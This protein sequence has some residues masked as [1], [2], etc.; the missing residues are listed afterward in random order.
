MPYYPRA[1]APHLRA[2]LQ[3]FP[4]VAIT[5]P[6][7]AG[8]STLLMQELGNTYTY[9]TFDDQ[10]II[11]EFYDDPKRFM[12]RYNHRVIFDEVQK[13]PEIFDAI[14]L[15]VDK[16]RSEYGQFILTG[17]SQFTMLK[18]IT[19]SLAGRIGLLTLLPLQCFEI[20]TELRL[21]SQYK[22]GYPELI[23]RNFQYADDWYKAYLTTYLERD[24]RQLLN[25][26]DM[27]AF[28]QLLKLLASQ[29]S[30]PLQISNLATNI[31][32]SVMTIKRWISVLE[33]SYIIF[34]LPPFYN[35]YGKRLIKRSKVY[36]YDPGLVAYLTRITTEDLFENGPLTGELFENYIVSEVKKK[37]CHS[38]VHA[39]LYYLKTEHGVEVDLI[40]DYTTHKQFVEI[41]HSSTFKPD[42][43]KA[44]LKFIQSKDRGVLVYNGTTRPYEPNLEIQYYQDFLSR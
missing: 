43:V 36:F 34:L 4:V 14:K 38:N 24:V 29:V 3:A 28:H 18:S 26:G 9:V 32:V 6:R 31:G 15:I 5:G 17:S 12:N 41:K 27:N 20:P 19:E 13:V 22:G 39:D 21:Q 33:A 40:V 42:M 30:Q 37:I 1:L 7:Q 16:N 10:E 2:Y 11:H 35:N 23:T 44:L 8:K 25:I